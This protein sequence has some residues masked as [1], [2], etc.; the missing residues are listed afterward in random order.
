MLQATYPLSWYNYNTSSR[1]TC[2]YLRVFK[3][4][5]H[6]VRVSDGKKDCVLPLPVLKD[7]IE[8]LKL[9]GAR[10]NLTPTIKR[11]YF[12]N[13]ENGLEHL[14]GKYW[15]GNYNFDYLDR[16]FKMGLPLTE[17]E[18][19]EYEFRVKYKVGGYHD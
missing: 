8:N 18:R 7:I 1:Y 12:F 14:R 6:W 4:K 2:G 19:K 17:T 16:K 10:F 3:Q 9:D 13:W 5:R 11:K 15:K